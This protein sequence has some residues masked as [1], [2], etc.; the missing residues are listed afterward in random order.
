LKWPLNSALN[1]SAQTATANSFTH[2]L[3][4]LDLMFISHFGL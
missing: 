2:F 1:F 3:I 4:G